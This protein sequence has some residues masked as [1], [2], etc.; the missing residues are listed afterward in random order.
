MFHGQY[1]PLCHRSI[2][3]PF[4]FVLCSFIPSIVKCHKSRNVL[5]HFIV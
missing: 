5:R 1:K 2:I 4:P 3:T